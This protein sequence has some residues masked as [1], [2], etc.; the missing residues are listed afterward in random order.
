MIILTIMF[1]LVPGAVQLG[2]GFLETNFNAS[3]WVGL[4][5][6]V[7][8]FTDPKL[9]RVIV[10]TFAYT[11]FFAVGVT[12]MAYTASILVFNHSRAIQGYIR[13]ALYIPQV[14]AGIVMAMIWSWIY[15][16]RNGLAN[17]ILGLFGFEKV[18]WFERA[19]TGIPA[20]SF[21][22]VLTN[23]GI[24]TMLFMARMLMLNNE[25]FDSAKVDGAGW[26][27]I[28]VRI[29][30]PMMLPVIGIVLMFNTIGGLQM[31]ESVY[32]MAPYDH[33]ANLMYSIY[34][35]GFIYSHYGLA[36]AQ[37]M[38]LFLLSVAIAILYRRA[39]D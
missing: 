29:V 14:T 33:M 17:Y 28:K 3:K 26:W 12:T 21:K 20:I 18:I 38:I 31:Y 1:S 8:V 34:T 5:N 36:A 25:I 15:S 11:V 30:T 27:D 9:L 2:L 6:Y 22:V 37:G 4:K 19:I 10:N 13:F 32:V 39:V 23:S 35:T 24:Y 16:P 7:K